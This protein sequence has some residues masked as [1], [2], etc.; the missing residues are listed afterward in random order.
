MVGRYE[1]RVSDTLGAVAARA[2]A[3]TPAHAKNESR[4][5]VE[6]LVKVEANSRAGRTDSAA[7]KDQASGG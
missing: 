4:R 6:R 2:S 3:T 5:I 7:A 1:K